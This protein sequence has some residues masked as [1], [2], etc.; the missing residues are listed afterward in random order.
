MIV[1]SVAKTA[2]ARLVRS[3]RSARLN[4]HAASDLAH[5]CQ[6][7]QAAVDAGNGLVGDTYRAR[8]DQGSGLSRVRGKVQIGVQ[9]LT[10]AEHGAFLGLR[11]LDLDDHIGLRKHASRIGHQRGASGLIERVGQTNS[12]ASTAL[13]QHAVAMAAQLAHA[14]WRQTDTI[15]MIFDFCG[16]AD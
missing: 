6:Q 14:S 15:F 8:L 4:S 5:G 9:N 11:L 13:H 12:L 16:P 2:P 1:K 3:R 10:G 7:W